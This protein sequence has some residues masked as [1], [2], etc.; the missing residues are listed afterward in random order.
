MEVSHSS[1]TTEPV[2]NKCR[3]HLIEDLRPYSCIYS[4]CTW[5]V[6]TTSNCQI[7]R[8]HLLLEHPN[9]EI[10]RT[11][12]CPLCEE[13]KPGESYALLTHLAKH[14]K[15]I[16]LRSLP[17]E[18]DAEEQPEMIEDEQLQNN[19]SE[20][21]LEDNTQTWDFGGASLS[22]RSFAPGVPVGPMRWLL[23][24]QPSKCC[25]KVWPTRSSFKYGHQR[26]VYSFC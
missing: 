5:D 14:L 18:V 10:W 16:A 6:K 26:L 20:A 2:S 1:F 12:T 7:W 23:W 11:H 4:S 13:K 19:A 8:D 17:G 24:S 22:D 25:G 21:S 3:Q 15:Q 9:E